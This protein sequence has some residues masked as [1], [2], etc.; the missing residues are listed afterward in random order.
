MPKQ[1]PPNVRYV[2]DEQI[3]Q[4]ARIAAEGYTVQEVAD[5]LE[6]NGL[7]VT[8]QA[9]S[10]MLSGDSAMIKLAMSWVELRLK[11]FFEREDGDEDPVRYWKL[12]KPCN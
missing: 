5:Q 10:K 3:F 1:F 4:F 6:E 11:S 8:R 2:S 12:V 7:K 9:V